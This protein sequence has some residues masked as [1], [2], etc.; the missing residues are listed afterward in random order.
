[1]SPDCIS[2]IFLLGTGYHIGQQAPGDVHAQAQAL[3]QAAWASANYGYLWNAPQWG[4]PASMGLFM[5]APVQYA[6][7]LTP[8]ATTSHSQVFLFFPNIIYEK[9]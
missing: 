2:T 5:P 4:V 7:Q 6:G 1:M 3:A 9:N 8:E